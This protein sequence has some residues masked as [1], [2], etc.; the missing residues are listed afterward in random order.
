[1][2]DGEIVF[3]HMNPEL[4]LK[5]DAIREHVGRPIRINS[6]YRTR[7]YNKSV[8]GGRFS[9]HLKGN[10][11]D[12]S[13]RGWKSHDLFKLLWIATSLDLSIG[14]Y[15]TFVHLDCRPGK[16]KVWLG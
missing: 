15:K 10:A 6:S 9:Q 4:L 3:Q 12:I 13:T 1:M 2:M 14:I 8:G 11:V 16:E 5:L 7:K